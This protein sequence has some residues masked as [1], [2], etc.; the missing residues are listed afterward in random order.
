MRDK[1]FVMGIFGRVSTREKELLSYN[2]YL[3]NLV[4]QLEDKLEDRYRLL[5]RAQAVIE[6]LDQKVAELE[7]K[8]RGANV[9]YRNLFSQEELDTLLR[10]CHPDKHNGRE[11]ATRITQKI[12]ELRGKR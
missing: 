3:K 7:Q 10:L 2:E 8:N 1:G 4:K 11:S 6:K 9:I 12:L 5:M